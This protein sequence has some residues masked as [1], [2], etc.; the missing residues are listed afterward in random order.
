MKCREQRDSNSFVEFVK[1]ALVAFFRSNVI[2]RRECVFGIEAN[3]QAVALCRRVDDV[4]DLL[5]TIAEIRSLSRG[6]FQCDFGFIA[7]A[8]FM[9]F[10]Q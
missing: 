3:P 5:E 7:L 2:T 1:R 6:D 8:G 4:S 10:V 9:D